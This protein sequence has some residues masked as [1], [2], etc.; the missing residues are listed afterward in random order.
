M[1]LILNLLNFLLHSLKLTL[2]IFPS[3]YGLLL[4]ISYSLVLLNQFIISAQL[5]LQLLSMFVFYFIL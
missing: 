3:F 4:F 5:F 1:I 2:C